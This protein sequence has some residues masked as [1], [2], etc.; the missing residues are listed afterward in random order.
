MVNPGKTNW[1]FVIHGEESKLCELENEWER[2]SV[3]TSWE[4]RSCFMPAPEDS[5]NIT[6]HV[7]LSP[8]IDRNAESQIVP[9]TVETNPTESQASMG[10]SLSKDEGES[11][12]TSVNRAS[13]TSSDPFLGFSTP[14]QP[15][16]P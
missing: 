2:I 8:S 11:N 13:I 4:I 15:H 12:S 1:W 7:S 16:K 3:Q 5:E 14:N 9:N 6:T 10:D